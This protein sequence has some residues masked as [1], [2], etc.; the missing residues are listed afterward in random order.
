MS[1]DRLKQAMVAAEAA[2]AKIAD[3]MSPRDKYE[4]YCGVKNAAV[5]ARDEV[6]EGCPD[7]DECDGKGWVDDEDDGGTKGCPADCVDG[8]DLGP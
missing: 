2:M 1:S 3:G 8:K 6:T 5:N 7:C 4:F